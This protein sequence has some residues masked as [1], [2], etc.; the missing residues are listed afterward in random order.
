[1]NKMNKMNV[2]VCL[3]F[4]FDRFSYEAGRHEKAAE[5]CTTAALFL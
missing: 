3:L 1:M 5:V 4:S 2:L